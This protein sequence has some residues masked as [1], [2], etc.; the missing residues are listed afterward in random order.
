[1]I[2]LDELPQDDPLR[3]TLHRIA[4]VD[5]DFDDTDV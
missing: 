1:L 3:A 5:F 4:D 2:W